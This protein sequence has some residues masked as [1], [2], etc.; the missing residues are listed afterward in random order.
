MN[1]L[2]VL[3]LLLSSISCLGIKNNLFNHSPAHGHLNYFQVL[4]VIHTASEDIHIQFFS[5]I[6]IF[7]SLDYRCK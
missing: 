2:F 7:V 3:F 5:C 6:Y 1:F 4:A